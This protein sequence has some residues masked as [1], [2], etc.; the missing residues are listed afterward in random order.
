M[1]TTHIIDGKRYEVDDVGSIYLVGRN[2]PE[3]VLTRDNLDRFAEAMQQICITVAEACASFAQIWQEL[4]DSQVGLMD[5][6][7]VQWDPDNPPETRVNDA[8]EIVAT[9]TKADGSQL[10]ATF[11]GNDVVEWEELECVA[12]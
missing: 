1:N 4:A 5:Y 3:L 10:V 7:A 11:K 9:T 12:G 6:L 2:G 8:G